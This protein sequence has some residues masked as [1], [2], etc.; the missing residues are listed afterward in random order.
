MG[1]TNDFQGALVN[2][3]PLVGTFLMGLEVIPWEHREQFQRLIGDLRV[4]GTYHSPGRE[5]SELFDALGSS[6]APSLR[7]PNPGAY[8]LGTYTD[9]NGKQQSGSVADPSAQKAYFTGITDQQAY[10][11][12]GSSG[13]ATWQAGKY[14]KF[15]AGIGLT[16]NQTHLITSADSCNPNLNGDVNAAGPCTKPNASGGSTTTGLPNPN[17]RDAI[18]LPGRRFTADDTTIVDLWLNG[19]VMF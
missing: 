19:V 10:G 7:T 4:A 3:P 8:H 6:Q 17:H 5:Y 14:I 15:N 9:A 16:F 2:H 13:S 1:Q 18:D 11:S 12:I